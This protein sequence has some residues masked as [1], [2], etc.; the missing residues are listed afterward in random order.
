MSACNHCQQPPENIAFISK[1]ARGSSTPPYG[2]S[3]NDVGSAFSSAQSNLGDFGDWV[4]GN[5][6]ASTFVSCNGP[7]CANY[8][9]VISDSQYRL[10]G[11]SATCYLK[12]WW[13]IDWVEFITGDIVGTEAHEAEITFSSSTK[14]C[15][16][17]GFK[18][19]DPT[20]WDTTSD[21]SIDAIYPPADPCY[22]P[23]YNNYE[24]NAQFTMIKYSCLAS[25]TPPDDGSANGFPVP[26]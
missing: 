3:Y 16:P 26:S 12:I 9:A 4:V 11:Y 17:D 22:S 24:W 19:S 7:V 25:Y 5:P 18:Q 1:Q 2:G 8:Q 14:G 23:H 13:K 15:L 10:A 21:Y 6:T 20:T